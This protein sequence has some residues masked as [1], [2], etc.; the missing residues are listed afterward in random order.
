MKD[1]MHH[2]VL[3]NMLAGSWKG[4]VPTRSELRSASDADSSP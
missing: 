3:P 2:E 1:G 4:K